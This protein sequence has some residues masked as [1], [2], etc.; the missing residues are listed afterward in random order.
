[1]KKLIVTLTLL[2]ALVTAVFGQ[3]GPFL[4]NTRSYAISYGFP[5]RDVDRGIID[6][7]NEE[8]FWTVSDADY[9]KFGDLGGERLTPDTPLEMALLSYYSSVVVNIR[10]VEAQRMLPANDKRAAGLALG[11]AT[12]Q[13]LQ[14]VRYFDARNTDRIG[15]YEGMLKF[16][17]DNNGVTRAEIESNARANIAAAVDAGFNQ[18]SFMLSYHNAVLTRNSNSGYTL[19]YGGV[20]TNNETRT[21]TANSLEALSREMRDGQ[22]KA[23]FKA[24]D[25][26]AVR[27]QAALIPAVTLS[28]SELRSIK[29]IL[30]AFY[31]NPNAGTY[32]AV[33][34]VSAI[35]GIM[36]A[37]PGKT[38]VYSKASV[39]YTNTVSALSDA[40]GAKMVQDV[41][42]NPRVVLR[43]DTVE[44]VAKTIRLR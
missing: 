23:D 2:S 40:L 37:T 3:S 12:Y 28:P 17:C 36:R 29:D 26:D 32:N 22:K 6:C 19:S 5:K 39:S 4:F 44:S 1:M 41:I 43:V 9:E 30:A 13:E 15:R 8:S 33:R 16:I 25:L 38:D 7:T 27:A 10:P 34:D 11:A 14:E 24:A 35:Y 20:N 21:I 18:V 42:A 31:Q